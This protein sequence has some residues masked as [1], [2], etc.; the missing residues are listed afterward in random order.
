VSTACKVMSMTQTTASAPCTGTIGITE[1]EAIE[2]GLISPHMHLYGRQICTTCQ[3]VVFSTKTG[4]LR[5]HKA[6]NWVAT[7]TR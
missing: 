7:V 1:T 6:I 3:N 4:A 2:Q 5:K